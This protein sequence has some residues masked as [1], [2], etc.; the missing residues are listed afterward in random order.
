MRLSAVERGSDLVAE[1]QGAQFSYDVHV[2]E[3][4]GGYCTFA[5]DARWSM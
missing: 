2:V 5:L 1:T 3:L 4:L